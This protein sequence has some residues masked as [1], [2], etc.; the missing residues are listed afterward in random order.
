MYVEDAYSFVYSS[1]PSSSTSLIL[2]VAALSAFYAS[3]LVVWRLYFHPLKHI[4]GPRLAAATFWYEYY[5]DVYLDG[6]YIKE[7]PR[8]HAEYGKSD[9]V[10]V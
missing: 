3:A 10:R 7:Y 8:L 4:P 5:H 9:H 2:L 6:R 1:L